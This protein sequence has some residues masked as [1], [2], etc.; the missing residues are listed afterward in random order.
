MNPDNRQIAAVA[1]R[2]ALLVKEV[3]KTFISLQ[4][5]YR[6]EVRCQ[7]GCDDCCYAVFTVSLMEAWSIRRE[8]AIRTASDPGLLARLQKRA[9]AY[10]RERGLQEEAGPRSRGDADPQIQ[11][12]QWR[13]RCPMLEDSRQC[14]IYEKRPLTCRIYGLPLSIEGKGHVCGFSGFEKGGGY[15]TVKMENLHLYLLELS[16]E[17]AKAS[18]GTAAEG[19]QRVF[20]HEIISALAAG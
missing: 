8:L 3:D 4:A 10:Q 1:D 15:P 5:Q 16:Q 9:A 20:L 17:L 6:E 11:L 14:A 2:F 13:I 19:G 12:A 7:A 18:G